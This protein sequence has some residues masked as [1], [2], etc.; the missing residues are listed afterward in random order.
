[1]GTHC[2]RS[3]EGQTCGAVETL[4]FTFVGTDSGQDTEMRFASSNAWKALPHAAEITQGFHTKPL[5]L[6]C[7]SHFFSITFVPKVAVS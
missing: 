3:C 6:S 5:G 7:H 1:M 2:L 4:A